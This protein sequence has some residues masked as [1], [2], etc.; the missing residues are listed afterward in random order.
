MRVELK[1]SSATQAL[2]FVLGLLCILITGL[3]AIIAF[4]GLVVSNCSQLTAGGLGFLA[5][6]P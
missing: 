3:A 4:H 2:T 5:Y 6:F 1:M